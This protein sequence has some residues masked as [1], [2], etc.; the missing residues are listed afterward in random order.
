MTPPAV[1][2][3]AGALGCLLAALWS[4]HA[5]V[6]LVA[7]PASAAALGQQ[8]GVRVEG[9]AAGLYPLEVATR[10]AARGTSRS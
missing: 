10:A 9:E 4:R 2:V 8:G 3:G 6:T 1:V 5:R 7:S